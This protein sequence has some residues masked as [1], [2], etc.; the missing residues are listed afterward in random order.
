MPPMLKIENASLL[1]GPVLFPSLSTG[2]VLC[3]AEI[4]CFFDT[5]EFCRGQQCQDDSDKAPD[6][7]RGTHRGALVASC[8]QG[9][10]PP[11]DL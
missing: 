5:Y 9:A 6:G 11:V 4:L 2:M 7:S 3:K 1:C 10:L 8:F